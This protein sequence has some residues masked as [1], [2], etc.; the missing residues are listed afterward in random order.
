MWGDTIIAFLLAFITAF[1]VTPKTIKLAKKL[2]A[3]DNPKDERRINKVV[4]PRLGGVAVLAGFLV[5]ISYLLISLTLEKQI[6]LQDGNYHLK[7]CGYFIGVIIIAVTCFIDDVKGVTA[8]V[9]LLAQIVAASVVVASGIRIDISNIGFFQNFSDSTN[10]LHTISTIIT[11]GWIVGIT[12][13]INLIDGLDGLSSGISIISCVSMLIIFTLNGS[14]LVSI[15]LITALIGALA[16]FLPYN[17]NPAKTFI[18][19]TGSN[20]LG[21]SLAVISI[22][23]V[24]KTYTAL[25]V[26]APIIILG[27]PI[28]DTL[29]AI[30]RRTIK[31]KSLKG[32]MKPDAGHLHHKLLKHGFSQKESVLILYAVSASLGMF[33]IILLES[34]VYKAISFLLIVIA[35]FALGYKEIFSDIKNEIDV[36]EKSDDK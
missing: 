15:I 25:V 22:I 8:V 29:F 16:G 26:V 23:G 36:E 31:N 11:I 12:N 19:D 21:F 4:M 6:N 20:F 14:P 17:L 35:A 24:A 34:G 10:F 18:G 7:L 33:A 28:F 13:A 5:S 27:L 2:G 1:M 30:V 9:K 32:I 3:V